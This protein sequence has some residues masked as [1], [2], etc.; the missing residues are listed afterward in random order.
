MKIKTEI[1]QSIFII[2]LEGPSFNATL[3]QGFLAAMNGFLT[4]SQLDILLD[5]SAVTTIDSTGLGSVVRSLK[6]INFPG[7]LIICGIDDRILN[8]LRM[9]G[10]DNIFIQKANR[11][12]SLSHL[13][14]TRKE[15][16]ATLNVSTQKPHRTGANKETQKEGAPIQRE[17]ESV[18]L[19]EVDEADFEEIIINEYRKE[20][21]NTVSSGVTEDNNSRKV[22]AQERRKHP[23][24]VQ[25][26]IMN[27]DFIIFCKNTVT[28]RHHPAMVLNISPGGL[29]IKSRS[30]LS[31]GDELL[32][33]GRIG[34][35]FKFKE[36]CISRSC[37]QQEYGLE[38]ID[39][40]T[41]TTHFLN[42]LIGSVDR[43]QSNK[44]LQKKK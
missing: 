8:F 9:T 31:I 1:F 15:T 24:I 13:F 36:R 23:R 7:E 28:G 43:R 17:E 19:W 6:E 3:T 10:L 29:L 12:T 27:D 35:H 14:W 5:L 2:T 41:E 34:R 22:P 11:G 20:T 44:F 16:N 25:K 30:E 18:M 42:Q 26:Q 40:S 37:R 33:D 21:N 32:L 38:F 39:L 4:K